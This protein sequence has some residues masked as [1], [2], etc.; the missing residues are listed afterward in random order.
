MSVATTPKSQ[1]DQPVHSVPPPAS[2][3]TTAPSTGH[4]FSP[5]GT[6]LL[7]GGRGVTFVL[8][9]PLIDTLRTHVQHADADA[10]VT[11][12]SYHAGR[13]Q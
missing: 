13:R 7:G 1:R 9:H 10:N 3:P 5:S 4:M 2:N 11:G 6:A 12:T 8:D